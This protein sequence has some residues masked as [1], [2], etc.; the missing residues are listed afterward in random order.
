MNSGS[1]QAFE[2][3]KLIL[4]I[5]IMKNDLLLHLQ[6]SGLIDLFPFSECPTH[7]QMHKLQSTQSTYLY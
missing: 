3:F 4:K 6:L 7:N 1:N 5:P 2:I